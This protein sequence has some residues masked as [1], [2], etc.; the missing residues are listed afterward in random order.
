M[1]EGVNGGYQ[2]AST[3]PCLLPEDSPPSN[4][5]VTRH[6]CSALVGLVHTL[7]P[8]EAQEGSLSTARGDPLGESA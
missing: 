4:F 8:L 5:M 2:D 1:N 3:W 7:A 6:W